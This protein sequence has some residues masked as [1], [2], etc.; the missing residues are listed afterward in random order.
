MFPCQCTGPTGNGIQY[1]YI[2]SCGNLVLVYTNNFNNKVGNVLGP[3][4]PTGA[5]G[6]IGPTGPVGN[7]VE[8]MYM[9]G[10]CNLIAVMT[11]GNVVNVGTYCCS[12]GPTGCNTCFYYGE[13]TPID[14]SWPEGVVPTPTTESPVLGNVYISTITGCMYIFDGINWITCTAPPTLVSPHID[15]SYSCTELSVELTTTL[16]TCLYPVE[17]TIDNESGNFIKTT[18]DK[19]NNTNLVSIVWPPPKKTS[20]LNCIEEG[21]Y[22]ITSAIDYNSFIPSFNTNDT[23]LVFYVLDDNNNFKQTFIVGTTFTVYMKLGYKL[24]T[25]LKGMTNLTSTSIN[26]A[27]YIQIKK[28]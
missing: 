26:N 13:N 6:T 1:S 2:D 27:V 25:Y 28:L 24:I 23:E 16:D 19:G 14:S 9:D 5:T 21:V 8:Y 10:C 3:T 15:S 22:T 7:G 17:F 18:V 11:N 20:Y 4:G 12:T